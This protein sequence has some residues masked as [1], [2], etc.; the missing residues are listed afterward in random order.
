MLMHRAVAQLVEALRYKQEGR[1][2][3]SRWRHWNLSLAQSFRPHYGPGVNSTSKRND[4]Q[5]GA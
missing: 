2:F 3:E 4:H 1:G 5:A